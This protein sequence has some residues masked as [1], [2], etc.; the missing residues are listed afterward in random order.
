LLRRGESL[1]REAL[2][3]VLTDRDGAVRTLQ[4]LEPAEDARDRVEQHLARIGRERRLEQALAAS[5][6]LEAV[7]KARRVTE[8]R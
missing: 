6:P 8:E 2:L 7:V 4:A 3:G 5:D 1:T